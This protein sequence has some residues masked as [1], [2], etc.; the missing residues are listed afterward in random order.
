MKKT[1]QRG[2]QS[3][4]NYVRV[5]LDTDKLESIQ[6][7]LSEMFMTRV[8]ILG[9]KTSRTNAVQI[10][11]GKRKGEFKAGKTESHMTNAEIGLLMERGRL[12]EPRIPARSFLEMP[13]VL[14]SHKLLEDKREIWSVFKGGPET[15]SRLKSAYVKLGQ[16]AEN[17]IQDAFE[18]GGFG[19]W[20]PDRPSTIAKKHSSRPLINT[21]QLRR[22]ISSDVV[23]R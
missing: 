15:R 3:S 6:T 23:T 1:F 14:M 8:G 2:S 10:T 5:H 21:A 13:L 17:L 7:A 11:S 20:D 19:L 22:S 4:G 9:N 12:S 16:V 18:T